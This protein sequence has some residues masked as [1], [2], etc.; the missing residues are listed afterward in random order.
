MAQFYIL[1]RYFLGKKASKAFEI[2]QDVEFFKIVEFL[3]P[4]FNAHL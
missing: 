2:V 1:K 4:L 3:S